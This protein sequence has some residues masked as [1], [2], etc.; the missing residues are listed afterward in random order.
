VPKE[1]KNDYQL[2]A[3]CIIFIIFILIFSSS[4]VY[5]A[6]NYYYY[7]Q[8]GSFRS[9]PKALHFAQKLHSLN[10]NTLIRGEDIPDLGY[11]YRVYLGPF[12]SYREADQ[13]RLELMNKRFYTKNSFIHKKTSLIQSNLSEEAESVI[14]GVRTAPENE[15]VKISPPAEVTVSLNRSEIEL[16]SPEEKPSMEATSKS[17]ATPPPQRMQKGH[18]RNI[19]KGKLALGLQLAYLETQTKVTNRKI[20]T[21]DGTTNTTQNVSLESINDSEYPTSMHLDTIHIRFG[22]TDYLEVFADTGTAFDKLSDLEFA[23]GGGIRLNL[24]EAS[25]SRQGQKVYFALQGDFMSGKLDAEYSSSDGSKWN[26]KSDWKEFNGKVEMGI[27]MFPKFAAYIGGVYC[28]YREDTERHLLENLPS[29]YTSYV[30]QDELEEE[31]NYGFY[32]GLVYHFLPALL[33]NIEGQVGNQEIVSG[34]LEYHF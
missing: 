12:P 5:C 4:P 32:G 2:K 24:F 29:G 23:Y 14:K 15:A 34:T 18:G 30:I 13:K 9:V 19:A 25:T 1:N 26:K 20:I 28:L 10:E 16:P 33:L 8:V 17:S 27:T 7:L 31:D 6:T 21:S 22:L 11:W 3:L